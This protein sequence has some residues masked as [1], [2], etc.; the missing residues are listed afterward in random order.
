MIRFD[1]L[2]RL[3]HETPAAAVMYGIYEKADEVL[4]DRF[5]WS[6]KTVISWAFLIIGYAFML[7]RQKKVAEIATPPQLSRKHCSCRVGKYNEFTT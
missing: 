7:W 1:Q 5:Q 6:V 4:F 3:L 2:F